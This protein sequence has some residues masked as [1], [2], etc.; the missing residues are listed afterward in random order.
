MPLIL[1]TKNINISLNSKRYSG[2]LDLGKDKVLGS[3]NKEIVLHL[4]LGWKNK[5]GKFYSI[6]ATFPSSNPDITYSDFSF[7]DDNRTFSFVQKGLLRII[8]KSKKKLTAQEVFEQLYSKE[9]PTK[10]FRDKYKI[11]FYKE[12]E[13]N[14]FKKT[15]ISYK[16]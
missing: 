10:P 3:K 7:D 4:T 15:I 8:P 14:I 12:K 6:A 2:Y 11:K 16:K 13:Y 9:Y 5:N 1:H